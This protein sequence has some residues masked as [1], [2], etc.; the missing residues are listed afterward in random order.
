MNEDTAH[1]DLSPIMK[2]EDC[3]RL[4]AFLADA[5][6]KNI[7]FECGQVA[8]V[9]GLTG[10]MLAMACKFW[11]QNTLTVSFLNASQGFEDG[12]AL[13]GLSALHLSDEASG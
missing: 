9:G 8:R 5:T 3:Q 4:H 12:M 10:Q 7:A 2:I 1:F 6:D 13:L 11:R